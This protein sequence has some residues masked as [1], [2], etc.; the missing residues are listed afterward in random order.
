MKVTVL[1]IGTELTTGQILNRNGQWL[2]L[3]L[4]E[5]GVASS[6]HL[7]VPDDRPLILSALQF[8]ESHSDIIFVTGGL[9]PTSDDFTRDLIAQWSGKTMQWHEASWQHIQDRLRDRNITVRE[10]QKQQCYFPEGSEILFNRQGTANA[11]SLKHNKVLVYVLPG[12]PKEIEGI[13]NEFIFP[14][15][16]A[17][18]VNLDPEVT[19]SWDT[20]G[21]GESDIAHLAEKALLGCNYEK[22]YRV[23]FP[24]VEFKISYPKSQAD[25]AKKWVDLIDQALAQMT[26]IKDGADAGKM[27]AEKLL[28]LGVRVVVCDE[29]DGSLVL[30]RLSTVA[31]KLLDEKKLEFLVRPPEKQDSEVLYLNLREDTQGTAKAELKWGKKNISVSE[32]FPSP[33]KAAILRERERQYFT[34]MALLFWARSL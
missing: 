30:G 8:C 9:G 27:L 11:F 16:K 12:P 31:R 3:K 4:K 26:A 19:R 23:H 5:L 7:V 34:E 32:I 18:A 2:S 28:T 6:A 10:I 33:Y 1:G 13:W 25:V 24:Y 22:G 21:F 15:V 29:I 17:L 14:Q 20:I